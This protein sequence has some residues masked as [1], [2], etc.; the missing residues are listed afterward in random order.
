MYP[1]TKRRLINYLFCLYYSVHYIVEY[2]AYCLILFPP[3]LTITDIYV[4][5]FFSITA[6]ETLTYR[7]QS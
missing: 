5:F 2:I 3:N 7:M 1:Q 4:S 6:P